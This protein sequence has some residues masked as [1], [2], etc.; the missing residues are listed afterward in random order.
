M[1]GEPSPDT[2]PHIL[3]RDITADDE[4][5]EITEIES[6]CFNCEEQGITRLFLTKIPYFREVIVSSFNCDKCGSHNA[7]LQPASRIQDKGCTFTVTVEKP[8]DLN[9]Q[10]VQSPSATLSIPSLDFE[11]PPHKG[12]LT[13]VEG[14]LTH[15]IDDL[16]LAQ[17]IR[18]VQDPELA[19][20]IDEF[21]EKMKKL[22]IIETPFDIVIDDPAG[23]SFVENPLAPNRD[24]NLGIVHYTR[25]R[26][27]D[28]DLG[29][30][31]EDEEESAGEETVGT[32]EKNFD[33]TQEVMHFQTNCPH[34]STPSETNMK[35][36]N[37]PHFKDVVIMATTCEACGY[38]DN[39]VKGGGGI[40]EKGHRITLAIE[41][42]DD[43]SRDM[44]KSDTCSISIPE[45]EFETEMGTLG[46]KF[47]TV[48]GLIENIRD[49]L[50]EDNPFM[51]GDSS[52]PLE[53][54]LMK[55]FCT[56]LHQITKGQLKVHLVLD[57]PAG[58]SYIQSLTAPDLDPQLKVER[59]ERTWQQN[60]ELGLND[61]K[62]ENY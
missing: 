6:L 21:I 46:G 4:E 45:L 33:T 12:M 50:K 54:G 60:E 44:L 43:M 38:R 15:T 22:L 16:N 18:K 8:Q 1:S 13:T 52:R 59:Y 20:K 29:L 47:T 51:T 27:Q 61:M 57:D 10:I 36:I 14:I 19:K 56:K 37:I 31:S 55:D 28:I 26:Q 23:N 39:E 42:R 2:K 41:G 9:R 3:F 11:A 34:C 48:E 25:T 24:P 49:Q 58:N 62:T 7:E 17:D 32:K 40:E 35:L 5:P 53:A 30:I